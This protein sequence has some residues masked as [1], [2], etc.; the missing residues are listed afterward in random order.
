MKIAKGIAAL[1]AAGIIG[2]GLT[3]CNDSDSDVVSQ[4]LSKD[5]DNYKVGRQIVVYNAITDKYILEV[6][7]YCALGNNDNAD[8]VSYTCKQG[9]GYVKDIILK[10]D[11]TF[12]YE[13][14]LAPQYVSKDFVKVVIKPTTVLNS[15]EIR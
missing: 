2:V 4:N 1:V 10:S 12:V 15:F 8:R 11:N 5:A 14:Q 13:H 3:A 9:N 6:R 7:G